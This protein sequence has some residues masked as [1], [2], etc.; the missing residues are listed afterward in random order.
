MPPAVPGGKDGGRFVVEGARSPAAGARLPYLL[1]NSATPSPRR[2]RSAGFTLIE[3]MVVILIIGLLVSVVMPNLDFIWGDA[4]ERKAK[5]DVKQIHEAASLYQKMKGK[6]PENLTDLAQKDEKGNSM[7]AE[8]PQDPWNN[9]YK[10]VVET[11]T[12]WK[13]VSYGPDGSEGGGDD[14]SS[15][16]EEN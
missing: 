3:V 12:K 2:S 1:M 16:K 15:V 7:L 14:I 6:L 8:L 9:D 5:I 4:Q 11:Q 13:V 10:L